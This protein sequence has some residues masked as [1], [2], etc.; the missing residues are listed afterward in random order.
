MKFGCQKVLIKIFQ[1]RLHKMFFRARFRRMDF[2]R[3]PSRSCDTGRN[4]KKI[5]IDFT[6]Q[7]QEHFVQ[8]A[9]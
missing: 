6:G 2:L 8:F 7:L 4:T 1:G 9:L 5:P 3:I